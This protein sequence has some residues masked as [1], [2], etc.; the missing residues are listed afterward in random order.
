MHFQEKAKQNLYNGN[1]SMWLVQNEN[2]LEI[3]LEVCQEFVVVLGYHSCPVWQLILH[4]T[5]DCAMVNAFCN[6]RLDL[7]NFMVCMNKFMKMCIL[8]LTRPYV[9]ILTENEL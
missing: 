7:H 1:W 8:F 4:A 2:H 5:G 3:L 9:Y 6:S